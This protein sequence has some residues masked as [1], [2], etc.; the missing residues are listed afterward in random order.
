M[1]ERELGRELVREGQC[2]HVHVYVARVHVNE[3]L[4][5]SSAFGARFLSGCS[6]R[7]SFLYC[8]LRS[9]SVAVRGTPRI[10]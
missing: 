9:A 6:C 7:A 3:P 4:K 5:A 10:S 2:L 1:R 8:F